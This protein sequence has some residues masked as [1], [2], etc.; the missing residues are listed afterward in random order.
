[1][2]K[3]QKAQVAEANEKAAQAKERHRAFCAERSPKFGTPEWEEAKRLYAEFEAARDAAR[4]LASGFA[5][6]RSEAAKRAAVTRRGW[7]Y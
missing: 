5:N 4:K 6:A 7:G 2:A 1:M 3:S